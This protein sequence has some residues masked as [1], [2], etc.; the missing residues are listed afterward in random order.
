LPPEAR[1][2]EPSQPL[3][4]VSNRLPYT[5]QRTRHRLVRHPSAGGLVSALDPVLQSRGG[6]WVG[7]PGL[8]L[9]PGE[10]LNQPGDPYRVEPVALTAEEVHSFYTGFSNSSL[11]PLFHSLASRA[12]FVRAEWETY[13]AVND[14]FAQVTAEHAGPDDLVWV[15][16]YQL[17]LLPGALRRLRPELRLA[18]FLHIPFPPYDVFRLLPW[19]REVLLGLLACDLVGFHIASYAMNFLDAVERRLGLRVDRAAGLVE[20]GSRTVHV[21]ALPLGIDFER[22]EDAARTVGQTSEPDDLQLIL[23]V[24]RLDYTKGISDRFRAL[25]HLLELHPEHL[26]RVVLLQ[27]AVPSRDEVAEYRRL[28]REID[29]LVGR[30]NGRFATADWSPIRYLYRQLPFDDLVSLYRRADVAFVT[31]LRDGMNLVA[32]E[33]V[34]CQV[35]D[36]GVLVLSR[37]TGAAETMREALLVNPYNLDETAHALHRALTMDEVERRARMTALRR[38]ERRDD[39]FAWVNAFLA[40]AQPSSDAVRPPGDVE[41]S[42]LLMPF[43]SSGPSHLEVVLDY[44]GTLVPRVD[45]GPPPPLSDDMRSVLESCAGRADTSVT[46]VGLRS[47]AEL[48]ALVGAPTVG[49]IGNHGLEISR[50]D[51]EPFRHEDYELYRQ[52]ADD[53]VAALHGLPVHDLQVEAVGAMV[54]VQV[55]PGSRQGAPVDEV[56]ELIREQG[57]QPVDGGTAIVARPPIGWDKGRAV[58]HLLRSSYGPEWPDRV[59]VVYVGDDQTDEEAFNQLSGLA[60]TFRVR[61]GETGSD[62]GFR[63]PT[64]D[65]V[66]ELLRWLAERP[67]TLGDTYQGQLQSS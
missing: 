67:A 11:W 3:T 42:S 33:Y 7:W 22:Y 61:S 5:I 41:F 58:L 65:S 20:H 30:I 39:V 49:L 48:G 45:S 10:T 43:L 50:P 1:T 64:I 38:R 53:L 46:I 21:T 66:R 60:M 57:F 36:P 52:K 34:A 23:G 32:K 6:T 14:H 59:R 17:M 55:P 28:K 2:P 25:E 8:E 40:E 26:G 18:F 15:H 56:L 62:A 35:G 29:E 9:Q 13:Q 19:D 31:P 24:D 63:L 44:D 54:N 51:L 16:D 27:L 37:M 47:V 4:V 12:R